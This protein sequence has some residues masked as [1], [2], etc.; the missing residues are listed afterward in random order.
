MVAGYTLPGGL[1]YVGEG[2]EAVAHESVEPALIDPRLPVNRSSP[3]HDGDGMTYWPAYSSIGP[4]NRAAYLE[5]LA[6][7]RRD[8]DAYIGYVFL[9]FYGLERRALL[10][11]KKDPAAL[12]ELPAIVAEIERLLTIYGHN[13]SFSNYAGKLL[14]LC[15]WKLDPEGAHKQELPLFRAEIPPTL[16]IAISKLATSSRPIPADL[17]FAWVM[18]SPEACRRTAATRCTAELRDLFRVRYREAYPNGLPLPKGR[19]PLKLEYRPASAS[20]GGFVSIFVDG[21]KDVTREGPP[22]ALQPFLERCV[23]ELEPYSRW[24][25]RRKGDQPN[26]SGLSLLP[27]PLLSTSNDPALVALRTWLRTLPLDR[28]PV[29]LRSTELLTRCPGLV[30]G[31]S[32]K[33]QS[34]SLAAFLEK[35]G[36]AIEPDV[37][38]LGSSMSQDGFI[39]LFRAPSPTM[40]AFSNEYRNTSNLLHFASALAAIDGVE[41]AEAQCLHDYVARSTR[42][43]DPERTRLHAHL[44]WLLQEPR[45]PAQLKKLAESVP[46]SLRPEL[47]RFLVCV[48][49]ADGQVSKKEV[50]MLVRMCGHLGIDEKT[51]YSFLH[52][53]S[54]QTSSG[55]PVTVKPAEAPR[56]TYAVPPRPKAAASKPATPAVH[57]DMARVQARMAES[58]AISEVLAD[59]FKEDEPPPPPQPIQ[60]VEQL[61]S[62]DAP[63]S[64]LV[65]KLASASSW[66]RGDWS[67]LCAALSLMPDGAVDTL[68]EAALDLCGEVLLAG[69]DP[70][71]VDPTV[72]REFLQ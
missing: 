68:N 13:G 66:T 62:L 57:L 31:K 1:L 28:E 51:V 5:W 52:G 24:L 7:G 42:L 71:E 44:L 18:N 67:Q 35:L 30:E 27:A 32:S 39:V 60:T 19:T 38:F 47:A 17:A 53:L 14:D 11:A 16:R 69:E 21:V 26:L 48:V 58:A 40:T 23:E 61:A 22:K 49:G 3:A 59:I 34:T 65:R 37:R 64:A 56:A 55:E 41:E 15:R 10:D 6:T 50:T 29:V 36:V 4:S 43:S 33:A 63:H 72:L 54:A 45:A 70:L 8:P 9:F 25:G 46:E 20:F 12:A 2:L